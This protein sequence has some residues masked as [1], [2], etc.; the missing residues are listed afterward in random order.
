MPVSLPQ[1]SELPC[2]ETPAGL[3]P[4][5]KPPC[6]ENPAGPPL[7][8]KPPCK[9]NP[10]GPPPMEDSTSPQPSV[11]DEGPVLSVGENVEN[12][13]SLGCSANG[14]SLEALVLHL[15]PSI[16]VVI[17]S[18]GN[19]LAQSHAENA[20]AGLVGPR[21]SLGSGRVGKWA[22]WTRPDVGS[23]PK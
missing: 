11:V 7:V 4:A 5:P 9:E 22:L 19:P 17:L 1:V 6:E 21:V 20:G 10:S 18:S 23:G 14:V 2:E 16:A 15:L 13:G 3:L 12:L 8:P